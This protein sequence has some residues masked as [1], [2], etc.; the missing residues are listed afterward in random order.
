[1]N[2]FCVSLIIDT[3]EPDGY[4]PE[5]P[6]ITST[7]RSQYRQFFSRIPMQRPNLIGL[8]SGE[9]DTNP[10]GEI[11]CPESR[12]STFQYL[13]CRTLQEVTLM[14]MLCLVT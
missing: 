1:M 3:Y 12:L 5:A 2:P 11:M 8:T 4:N 14:K 13:F 7:G 9:M 6:S 10:R